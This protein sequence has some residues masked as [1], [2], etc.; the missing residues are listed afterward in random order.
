MCQDQTNDQPDNNIDTPA[1][2][3]PALLRQSV[4][5]LDV[6]PD[7]VYVDVTL[8]GAGHTREIL[9]RLGPRG[10]FTPSIATLMPWPQRLWT[11]AALR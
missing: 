9:R 7:G 1:Y 10:G 11:T 6:R 2:H 5:A 4:D 8:G 3:I